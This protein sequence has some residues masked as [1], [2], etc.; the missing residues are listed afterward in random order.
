M[1]H[2]FLLLLTFFA[3][4]AG[5]QSFGP[6]KGFPYDPVLCAA[7]LDGKLYLG[8][9]GSGIYL[10]DGQSIRPD[11]AFAHLERE[12]VYG[13]QVV[14]GALEPQL[15]PLPLAS[16]PLVVRD[17]SGTEYIIRDRVLE[18]RY[19]DQ[20]RKLSSKSAAVWTLRN[21][22]SDL[23][24]EVIAVKAGTALRLYDVQGKRLHSRTFKGLVFD[25]ATTAQGTL[26]SSEEGLFRWRRGWVKLKAS[27]P[28]FEFLGAD[29]VR[30]PLGIYPLN[31]VL[32]DRWLTL[33]SE[34]FEPQPLEP[35]DVPW[36]A[37]WNGPIR[38]YDTVHLDGAL[39]AFTS[40]GVLVGKDQWELHWDERRGLPALRPGKYSAALL[41][42]SVLLAMPSGLYA[43][44]RHGAP[45]DPPPFELSW[46][47]N[48]LAMGHQPPARMVAPESFGFR[49]RAPRTGSA[50]VYYR[51]A[52]NGGP[53][54][55]FEPQEPIHFPLP[56]AGRY[57]IRVEQ[58]TYAH[59]EPTQQVVA[60]FK[61]VPL[62]YK[63][64]GFWAVVVA[65]VAL[66]VVLQLRKKN[67]RLAERLELEERLAN[68]ELASKRLQMNPHFLFNALDAI[69]SFIMGGQ[70]KDAILYMG[71]LAKLLR[72]TLDSARTSAMVLADECDLLEQYLAL[73]KL[74]YG[75]FQSE[76]T[77]APDIDPYDQ[78]VPPMLLQPLVENAV[79]YAVRPNL[80][81]K[82]SAR[83]HIA[84]EQA[85]DLL[86]IA[87]EDNGPG[88]QHQHS[89]HESHGLDILRERLQLLEK[90]TG[91]PH[92]LLIESPLSTT[93][94]GGTRV[95]L[96]VASL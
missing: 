56:S 77:L 49:V 80:A 94:E 44:S 2:L 62:W 34:P 16:Y 85:G 58:S 20:F 5:A 37:Q 54:T 63:R 22:S 11:S 69:S 24:E 46:Q 57:T 87:I 93:A 29:R 10:W 12:V 89:S 86:V 50:P 81:K 51:Y 95:T 47:R 82:L 66:I 23:P 48:G 19:S 14:N 42:D 25:V 41:A 68:A 17:E 40:E 96:T 33:Q 38:L 35:S 4:A 70:R 6:E 45:A 88:F 31:A 36:L 9:Q 61:V 43:A 3:A 18:V 71:K 67:R 13:L 55:R 52:I 32:A 90:K 75:D 76:V 79:Q 28:V 74:R 7:T 8:T 26:L 65:F 72:F 60:T 15:S 53:Y 91:L 78:T 27:L 92:N 1:K 59:F 83:V 21:A 39:L 84:F 64:T 30:T 73:S